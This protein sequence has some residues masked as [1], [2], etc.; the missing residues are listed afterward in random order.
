[1]QKSVL[2]ASRTDRQWVTARKHHVCDRHQT[3]EQKSQEQQNCNGEFHFALPL[4]NL[5]AVESANFIAAFKMIAKSV[6]FSVKDVGFPCSANS[7]SAKWS[8]V[9]FFIVCSLTEATIYFNQLIATT[10][11]SFFRVISS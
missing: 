9:V 5:T 7:A 2:S 11:L 10:I 8:P 1:M 6:L 3:D 4:V